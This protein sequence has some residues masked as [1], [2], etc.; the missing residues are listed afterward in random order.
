MTLSIERPSKQDSAENYSAESVLAESIV[1]VAAC[2]LLILMV[3]IV[4][5]LA[6]SGFSLRNLDINFLGTLAS[7]F[8]LGG[9]GLIAIWSVKLQRKSDLLHSESKE[10]S[11][12]VYRAWPGSQTNYGSG[13]SNTFEQSPDEVE[14]HLSDI[15]RGFKI[16]E[17]T[18][19]DVAGFMLSSIAYGIEHDAKTLSRFVTVL[20]NTV[21]H[22][23]SFR[24]SPVRRLK[25]AIWPKPEHQVIWGAD[26]NG[27]V[28]GQYS[29]SVSIGPAIENLIKTVSWKDGRPAWCKTERRF[30][31]TISE[32]QKIGLI[33]EKIK[34]REKFI[35]VEVN[36]IEPWSGRAFFN[37]HGEG[38]TYALLIITTPINSSTLSVNHWTTMGFHSESK[39]SYRQ[40]EY[41]YKTCV[42]GR[43]GFSEPDTSPIPNA[44]P[45]NN[46]T[47]FDLSNRV[48]LTRLFED[49]PH[50]TLRQ[51]FL[52]PEGWQEWETEADK[53]RAY[54]ALF[55]S[56]SVEPDGL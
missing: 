37:R 2:I 39:Y 17:Q 23:M 41:I 36:E 30:S 8:S 24:N 29:G 10:L 16:D 52:L 42:Q 32:L 20:D 5:Q 21:E 49:D 28:E 35:N 11:E 3:V 1:V 12:Y 34:K 33:F 13:L 7:I 19:F 9:A 4:A 6:I 15:E 46:G 25:I 38:E 56:K 40:L 53:T 27:F 47:R 50:E 45:E 48:E 14:K 55:P 18:N 26:R 22:T 43:R 44:E 51:Y 31:D 54:N